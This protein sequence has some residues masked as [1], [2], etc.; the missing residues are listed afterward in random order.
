MAFTPYHNLAGATS[1]RTELL[2][3]GDI[4]R[5]K[6]K[7]ILAANTHATADATLDIYL[8]K[9]STTTSEA[10]YYYIVK[11]LSIPVGTALLIEN[12]DLLNFDNS[13]EGYSL[14]TYTGG[15]DTIDIHIKR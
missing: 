9:E 6:I 7:A 10:K 4:P 11:N 5:E 3:V 2:A 8:F 1:R 15:S 13:S 14:Q 12:D